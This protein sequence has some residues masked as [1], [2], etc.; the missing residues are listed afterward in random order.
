MPERKDS[1][2][3]R[4]FTERTAGAAMVHAVTDSGRALWLGERFGAPFGQVFD[5][6]LPR[7]RA[8]AG[9]WGHDG[10]VHAP[11]TS[12]QRLELTGRPL[13]YALAESRREAACGAEE[14]VTNGRVEGGDAADA[15]ADPAGDGGD[16]AAEPKRARPKTGPDPAL[17]PR[18]AGPAGGGSGPEPAGVPVRGRPRRPRRGRDGVGVGREPD[19]DASKDRLRLLQRRR[20]LI[21][22]Q[23]E[24]VEERLWAVLYAAE[25]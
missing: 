16:V 21:L 4:L 10:I 20:R 18:D 19:A 6:D 22:V 12:A 23:I 14:D 17:G 11:G 7:L 5:Q 24:V 25:E 13:R 1:L 2:R 15:A 8:A 9:R 3:L